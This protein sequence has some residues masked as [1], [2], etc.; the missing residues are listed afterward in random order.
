MMKRFLKINT[1]YINGI[2][3]NNKKIST[4]VPKFSSYFSKN[5]NLLNIQRQFSCTSKNNLTLLYCLKHTNLI[6]V[7][8]QNFSTVIKNNNSLFKSIKNDRVN[9]CKRNFSSQ[10]EFD[11]KMCT[12]IFI[13]LIIAG[14]LATGGLVLAFFLG[15][16]V[17]YFLISH[18][19][20]GLIILLIF[21]IS[22]LVY[23]PYWK[24][25]PT[26]KN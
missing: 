26:M 6:K 12:S 3:S 10:Q 19:I 9:V 15:I 22:M 7:Q 1:N 14:S 8:R 13:A 11:D 24:A 21:I 18:P 20:I 2:L 23:A 17:I 16:G 4:I 25:N 5:L